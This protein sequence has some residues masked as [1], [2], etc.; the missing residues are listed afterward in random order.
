MRVSLIAV[1]AWVALAV[2][3]RAQPDFAGRWVL[4]GASSDSVGLAQT[5]SVDVT[6]VEARAP[7]RPNASIQVFSVSREIA[8]VVRTET[9]Q[10]GIEGGI[11]G[12]VAGG[13]PTAR[14]TVQTFGSVAWVDDC[15]VIYSE[16]SSGT[17]DTG[18]TDTH[19]TTER[20]CM[21]AARQL[22][23]AIRRTHSGEATTFA[24]RVYR[25]Q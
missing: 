17:S 13:S 9:H 1:V 7:G 19:T 18:P 10:I 8:G 11:V 2:V 15:L 16:R 21:N 20:W 6:A 4:V 14:P 3:A 12:G 25:R 5:V 23:L 22:V 24:T